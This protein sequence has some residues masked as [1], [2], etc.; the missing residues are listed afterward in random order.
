MLAF[1]ALV[2]VLLVWAVYLFMAYQT[3][4]ERILSQLTS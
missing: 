3:S 1:F 2:Y 4:P